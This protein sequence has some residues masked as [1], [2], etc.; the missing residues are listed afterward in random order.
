[1]KNTYP[2][3]ALALAG[4]GI[5]L[6]HDIDADITHHLDFGMCEATCESIRAELEVLGIEGVAIK[7]T[8]DG[9][10]VTFQGGK[11]DCKPE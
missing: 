11:I 9:Y 6:D 3:A 8:D 5:E 4:C 1:M 2:L 7:E 10:E